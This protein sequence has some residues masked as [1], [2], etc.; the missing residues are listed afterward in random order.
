MPCPS[1]L[2]IDIKERR[3]INHKCYNSRNTSITSCQ[4]LRHG[5]P[6]VS[7]IMDMDIWIS[8][9]RRTSTGNRSVNRISLQ[10]ENKK[11]FSG[12]SKTMCIF[13]YLL[14]STFDEEISFLF[15]L[16]RFPPRP[17]KWWT[18]WLSSKKKA[19]TGTTPITKFIKR[20]QK[21]RNR[22][23]GNSWAS[24]TFSSQN[25]FF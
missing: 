6:S 7:R 2:K 12:K 14:S 16:I 22:I 9:I 11:E 3:Q 13:A 8:W 25:L 17:E 21:I 5:L 18:K 4:I 23:M 20:R 24:A 15:F 1:A 10:R 19:I